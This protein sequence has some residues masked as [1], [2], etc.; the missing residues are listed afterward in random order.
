MI[1]ILTEL[2]EH[3][4][5]KGICKSKDLKFNLVDTGDDVTVLRIY[6]GYKQP[7]GTTSTVQVKTYSTSPE[8]AKK[9]IHQLFDALISREPNRI[10]TINNK[11]MRIEETQPPFFEEKDEQNRFIWIFNISITTL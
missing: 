10:S 8:L 2:K 9:R 4:V 7:V 1:D 6:G 11:K 5:Q 3:I